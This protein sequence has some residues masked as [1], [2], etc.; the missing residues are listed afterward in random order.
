M[1]S[2]ACVF[3]LVLLNLSL[4]G[5]VLVEQC[6][7]SASF[8]FDPFAQFHSVDIIAPFGTVVKRKALTYAK[9][10][11]GVGGT[12][13]PPERSSYEKMREREPKVSRADTAYTVLPVVLMSV[14]TLRP[15]LRNSDIRA[16]RLPIP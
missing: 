10:F 11:Q 3:G 15:H 6:V 16:D 7:V 4:E 13:P 2:L 14:L 12:L 5:Q 8:H 1:F 9:A